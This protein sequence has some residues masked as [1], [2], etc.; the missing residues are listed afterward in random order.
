MTLDR[1]ELLQA[2]V[3]ISA[4]G[5]SGAAFSAALDQPSALRT[6]IAAHLAARADEQKACI[7]LRRLTDAN[8]IPNPR[9]QYGKLLLGRDENGTDQFKPMYAYSVEDIEEQRAR[10]LRLSN[11]FGKKSCD[12]I[13]ARYDNLVEDLK[14]QKVACRA[15][16]D[17]CGFTAACGRAD[18]CF[19]STEVAYQAIRNHEYATLD[20]LRLAIEHIRQTLAEDEAGEEHL[21]LEIGE[22]V[23]AVSRT[24]NGA[25]L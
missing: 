11:L 6:K 12:E 4:A 2:M 15:A 17:A 1:R 14:R 25:A 16:E 20:D 24:E 23:L 7:E 3:A 9:V 5:A 18:A 10:I 8:P 22:F 19:E 13:N 21:V